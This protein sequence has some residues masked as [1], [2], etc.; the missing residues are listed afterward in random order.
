[1]VSEPAGQERDSNIICALI[2]LWHLIDFNRCHASIP[3]SCLHQVR[4][5]IEVSNALDRYRIFDV[6]GGVTV[7]RGRVI[8]NQIEKLRTGYAIFRIAKCERDLNRKE[9]AFQDQTHSEAGSLHTPHEESS[10]TRW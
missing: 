9:K 8:S 4:G 10:A 6:E 5:S 2:S 1:M 3:G 7:G